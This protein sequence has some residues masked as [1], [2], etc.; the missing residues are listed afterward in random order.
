MTRSDCPAARVLSRGDIHGFPPA[1]ASTPA[2]NGRSLP[3][4]DGLEIRI[5]PANFNVVAATADGAAGSLRN[6]IDQSDTNGDAENTINLGA[7]AIHSPTKPPGT[8]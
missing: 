1:I 7:E 2:A 8:C 3:Y 4:L 6:A 5:T